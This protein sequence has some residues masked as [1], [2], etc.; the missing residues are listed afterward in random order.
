MDK[1][2]EKNKMR[3]DS[4]DIK[5]ITPIEDFEDPEDL[6]NYLEQQGLK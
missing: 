5:N 3:V 2:A 6:A 1:M 4:S